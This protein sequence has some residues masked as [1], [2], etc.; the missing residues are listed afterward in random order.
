MSVRE[1]R[2][3]PL[4][5]FSRKR[6]ITKGHMLQGSVG[7][8]TEERLLTKHSAEVWAEGVKGRG[9]CYCTSHGKSSTVHVFTTLITLIEL[10]FPDKMLIKGVY[11]WSI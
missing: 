3:V 9:E 10:L 5:C 7:G 2:V 6:P 11:I 4:N 8:A 1:R